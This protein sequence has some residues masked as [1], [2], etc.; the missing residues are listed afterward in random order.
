MQWPSI[1]NPRFRTRITMWSGSEEVRMKAGGNAVELQP[2]QPWATQLP[3]C[4]EGPSQRPSPVPV[5]PEVECSCCLRGRS[6]QVLELGQLREGT[7]GAMFGGARRPHHR[8]C[9]P[10]RRWLPPSYL[11]SPYPLQSLCW[12]IWVTFWPIKAADS[13]ILVCCGLSWYYITK[14]SHVTAPSFTEVF[15]VTDLRAITTV[16][17]LMLSLGVY[18]TKMLHKIFQDFLNVGLNCVLGISFF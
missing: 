1:A 13:A 18:S 12:L 14:K 2:A 9:R 6:W 10:G 16:P 17:S 7:G 5:L 8:S 3:L 4:R 15:R 11:R